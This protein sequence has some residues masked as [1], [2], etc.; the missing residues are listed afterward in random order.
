MVRSSISFSCLWVVVAMAINGSTNHAASAAVLD[1]DNLYGTCCQVDVIAPDLLQQTVTAGRPGLLAGILVEMHQPYGNGVVTFSLYEGAATPSSTPIFT[2]DVDTTPFPSRGH[3]YYW[4][5]SSLTYGLDAGD[6]F[7]F[8]LTGLGA[9]NGASFADDI[10]GQYLGGDLFL[11]GESFDPP[12]DLAFRTWVNP[13]PSLPPWP[14]FPVDDR[15]PTGECS[16]CIGVPLPGGGIITAV[17]D[18]LIPEFGL[19]DVGHIESSPSV[20]HPAGLFDDV[21]LFLDRSGRQRADDVPTELEGADYVET[22]QNNAD[23]MTANGGS[24][25]IA[26]DV[27]KGGVIYTVY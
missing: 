20:L 24:I 9:G 23:W 10:D 8:G 16:G 22:S 6:V 21:S 18:I 19:P 17:E 25:D 1:Q 26:I 27:I 11:N 2:Q 13:D 5:V 14:E 12:R 4:D 15:V 7:T 3:E